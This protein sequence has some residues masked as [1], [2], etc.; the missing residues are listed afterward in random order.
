MQ[1]PFGH[2]VA[3]QMHAPSAL[4]VCPSEHATQ[5]PPSTPHALLVDVTHAPARSQHPAVQD[6]AVQEHMPLALQVW[7]VAQAMQAAPLVPHALGVGGFT[8]WPLESQQPPG[9]VSALQG[10]APSVGVPGPVSAG[11]E[12]VTAPSSAPSATVASWMAAS[13]SAPSSRS[14]AEVSPPSASS[15]CRLLPSN[16]LHPALEQP[17]TEARLTST[18]LLS[19]VE[20]EL[21]GSGPL[22]NVSN[23][24]SEN[25]LEESIQELYFVVSA[26]RAG[27]ANVL[28][29]PRRGWGPDAHCRKV[30]K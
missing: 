2:D 14:I 25:G 12:S 1:H 23:A 24:Y 21:M 26:L 4:Q 18:Q 9:Q 5:A 15:S 13:P 30:P 3:S 28:A 19:L 11:A 17:S 6:A 27:T 8:Q 29:R 7:P 10:P 22:S 20:N 16:S